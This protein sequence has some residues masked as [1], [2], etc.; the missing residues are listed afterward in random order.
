MG[1]KGWE[2]EYRASQ[3]VEETLGRPEQTGLGLC[4]ASK[5]LPHPKTPYVPLNNPHVHL[6]I[7][8]DSRDEGGL[9]DASPNDHCV[10]CFT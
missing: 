9:L 10:R 5:G 7:H 3:E 2:A 4:Y 6:T 1:P 8:L